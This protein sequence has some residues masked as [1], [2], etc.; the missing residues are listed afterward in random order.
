MGL[1]FAVQ[2][3]E[4]RRFSVECITAEV[5]D[6]YRLDAGQARRIQ[7]IN[8]DF[9]D[10]VNKASLH[11]LLNEEAC[12]KEIERLTLE[13]NEAVMSVVNHRMNHRTAGRTVGLQ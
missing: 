3:W 12:E 6:L 13:K 8:Y 11:Y 7:E 2:Q 9:Y 10:R 1:C 4:D 5:K